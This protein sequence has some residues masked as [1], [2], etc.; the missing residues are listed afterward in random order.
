MPVFHGN[1]LKY[2]DCWNVR[3]T[4]TIQFSYSGMK[5]HTCKDGGSKE[6]IEKK[7][8]NYNFWRTWIWL[9]TRIQYFNSNWNWVIF[10]H[11]Q[12]TLHQVYQKACDTAP[13][14]DSYLRN[15]NPCTSVFSCVNISRILYCIRTRQDSRDFAEQDNYR[16]KDSLWVQCHRLQNKQF[17][18]THSGRGS[19]V[20]I[21]D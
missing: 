20:S 6:R 11:V 4:S 19:H 14:K 13:N 21:K 10:V 9:I 12:E 7:F 8:P 16:E 18:S 5:H 15:R 2:I 1:E 17:C 3:Q